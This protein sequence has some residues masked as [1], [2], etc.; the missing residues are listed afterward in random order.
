MTIRNKL[1]ILI[2]AF[3]SLGICKLQGQVIEEL[4]RKPINYA[5]SLDGADN[6][7][8]IGMGIFN[9][10]WTI[11]AWIKG[12]DLKWKKCE[13][14]IGTGEYGNVIGLDEIPLQLKDG[15][16]H[17]P[18]AKI[19]SLKLLDDKWHYVALSNDGKQTKLYQ[20]GELV[21]VSNGAMSIL[22]GTIGVNTKPE[23]T[24]GGM[25]DEVRIWNT[26]IPNS[27]LLQWAY[28]SLTA[29]HPHFKNLK[30]Y[31]N[32]DQ[33]TDDVSL[34]LVGKGHQ[35]FHM[36]NTRLN[37]KGNIPL[38]KLEVNDNK[39]FKITPKPQELFNAISIET[40][41]DAAQGAK[42]NQLLKLRIVTNGEDKPLKLTELVLDFLGT[43]K[44]S[45]IEKVHVYDAGQSPR[46]KKRIEILGDGKWYN[47]KIIFKSANG[48]IPILKPG[49][50]YFLVTLDI[51]K[52]AIIGDTLKGSVA[53]FSLNGKK[54][55]AESETAN[56]RKIIVP[57]AATS[58][59]LTVLQWNIWHGGLHM[60]N[61]GRN[62][63]KELI[64]S[65]P[66]DVV[67]I[68][69]AYGIQEMLADSLKFNMITASKQANL[70]LFSRYPLEK[71]SSKADFNSNP[72]IITLPNQTQILL[73]NWWLRYA[74]QPEY[75][76]DYINK[77]SDINDWIKEDL[78]LGALDAKL[79]LDN[80]IDPVIKD[81][82]MPIIIAG[83]FNSGSHLDW[84][85][86][87]A[88][89]HNG[90]GP[91]ALPISKFMMDRGYVDSFRVLHPNE[92]THPAGTFAVIFGQLQTSRIDYIYYKGKGLK[93]I[94]SKIIRSA[95]EI[96]DVWPS[97]HAA[98]ITVFEIIK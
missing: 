92:V 12:N 66:A 93:P 74:S 64:K 25:I 87:A 51:K 67:C 79:S 98:V 18:L 68:Q 55:T 96:D 40:E 7:P 57:A 6:N 21:G 75:T 33:L 27:T 65:T 73:A 49:V 63:V 54:Y 72:A 19:T 69:E 26:A 81:R 91:V 97:D 76:D 15:R 90:Y 22:P 48:I 56:I 9:S 78:R 80:D 17:C 95:P 16:L 94:S 62:R 13:A 23:N 60:G 20:D 11:E 34:N 14:I 39:K 71:L 2:F 46:D 53:S 10:P 41:W 24:F 44:L 31:Y 77:G 29:Q 8:C 83:D 28:T 86:R 35:A 52:D 85:A 37:Y 89:L 58:N 36:R 5:L 3:L 59:M 30:G 70:A 82:E 1:F 45:A 88:H 32:F 50:N 43:T 42:N 61:N 38:A 47:K 4:I 84:T